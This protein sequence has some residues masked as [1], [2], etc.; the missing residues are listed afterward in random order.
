[1]VPAVLPAALMLIL[2]LFLILLPQYNVLCQVKNECDKL[3]KIEVKDLISTLLKLEQ[4]NRHPR[5]NESL[6][7][8]ESVRSEEI[9]SST[10]YNYWLLPKISLPPQKLSKKE[11]KHIQSTERPI[12]TE[13]GHDQPKLEKL[14]DEIRYKS[15]VKKTNKEFLAFL[16]KLIE[17]KKVEL[18]QD[19]KQIKD[20]YEELNRTREALIHAYSHQRYNKIDE[21]KRRLA[22]KEALYEQ[23]MTLNRLRRCPRSLRL[24]YPWINVNIPGNCVRQSMRL[25]SSDGELDD[26]NDDRSMVTGTSTLSTKE[27]VWTSLRKFLPFQK[28]SLTEGSGVPL[29]VQYRVRK[30]VT[31][32]TNRVPEL[33]SGPTTPR[34]QVER[35]VIKI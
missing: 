20:E 32:I 24:D 5:S 23:L 19:D 26:D 8:D 4:L 21:L 22:E 10:V 34:S 31:S 17:D 13:K 14:R 27:L 3:S 2:G 15:L 29:Q 12:Q 30:D 28:G 7:E 1:M 35:D 33:V 16:D 9:S 25:K 18:E 11:V 6:N